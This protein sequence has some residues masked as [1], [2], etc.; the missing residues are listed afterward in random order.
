MAADN[1]KKDL[2]DKAHI[3]IQGFAYIAI[4]IVIFCVGLNIN[5]AIQER[6]IRVKYIEI[7]TE[8]LR[9]KPSGEPDPLRNW[10]IKIIDSYSE[11]A[12]T[13]EALKSL[14]TKPISGHFLVDD[15]GN[16]L[17]DD[18]GNHLTDGE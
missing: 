11:I 7:A 17:V 9:D 12:L 6:S 10:A 4:P 1:K 16:Y 15:E 2:W 14:R 5:S 18:K 13:E 8:I 3:L